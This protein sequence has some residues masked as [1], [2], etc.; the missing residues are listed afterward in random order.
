MIV[1]PNG[2]KTTLSVAVA[3]SVF[4]ALVF[5]AI[6]AICRWVPAW[7]SLFGG[8]AIVY[9]AP[10]LEGFLIHPALVI[11]GM[12]SCP[13]CLVHRRKEDDG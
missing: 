6:I 11:L 8:A 7:A 4:R 10:A 9:G 13:G 2:A 1:F 5:A 3:I 12:L